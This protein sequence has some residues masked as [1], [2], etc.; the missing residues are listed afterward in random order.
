[1]GADN[2]VSSAL[3]NN[4]EYG[5]SVGEHGTLLTAMDPTHVASSSQARN[6]SATP[7]R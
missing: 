5:V 7:P 6:V 3:I 4:L 1:D 2:E